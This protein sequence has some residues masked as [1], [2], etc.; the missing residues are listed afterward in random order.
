[1]KLLEP[2]ELRIWVLIWFQLVLTIQSKNSEEDN[3]QKSL[4][5][6][7]IILKFVFKIYDTIRFKLP[8]IMIVKL[9]ILNS[10]QEVTSFFL[11]TN[12]DSFTCSISKNRES[13]LSS[14][15][16]NLL[17]GYLTQTSLLLKTE[18]IYAFG[19]VSKK[20]I[21]LPCIKLKEM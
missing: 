19:I 16:V 9:T 5:I 18:I 14:T 11:E 15:I 12:V 10:I 20:L 2:V 3:Q 8:S 17:L 13:K 6:F 1:M 7:L 4:L 21:R